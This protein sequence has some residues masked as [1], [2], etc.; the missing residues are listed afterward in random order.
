VGRVVP[1]EI[2]PF[3]G[4][5]GMAPRRPP[6]PGLVPSRY[7]ADVVL[8]VPVPPPGRGPGGALRDRPLP[9]LAGYGAQ[10]APLPWPCS[11]AV[12]RRRGP[13]RPFFSAPCC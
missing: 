9:R 2:A 6:C 13:G 4:S 12:P 8:G 11:L 10:E 7:L 5:L 1:C 3:R